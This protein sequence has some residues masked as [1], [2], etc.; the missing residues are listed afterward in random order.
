MQ[1]SFGQTINITHEFERWKVTRIFH[2]AIADNVFSYNFS[3]VNLIILAIFLIINPMY[4]I[5]VIHEIKM[6]KL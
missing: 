4:L 5:W 6:H 2:G 1:L 3:Q